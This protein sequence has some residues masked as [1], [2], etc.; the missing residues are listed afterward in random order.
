MTACG[1]SDAWISAMWVPPRG[2]SDGRTRPRQEKAL[3]EIGIIGILVV[4]LL[5]LA[6][7]YFAKRV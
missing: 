5:I 6:I 2:S 1:R 7:V 4:I 3:M